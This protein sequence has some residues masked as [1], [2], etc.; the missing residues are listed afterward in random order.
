MRK[1]RELFLGKGIDWLGPRPG[2]NSVQEVLSMAI[3]RWDP[4]RD[5]LNL[6][7]EIGR[8][9]GRPLGEWE[10]FG[11]GIWTPAIDMFESDS[12][13]VVKAELPGLTAK[14]IDV[15]VD[16]DM[17]TIRG[18]R[19]FSREAKEENYYRLERR[20]GAFERTLPLPSTIQKNKAKASFKEG[21]LEIRMPKAKGVEAKRVKVAVEAGESKKVEVKKKR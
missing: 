16:D 5:L 7:D 10:P 9:F 2:P 3:I 21:V 17:L 11:R 12:E 18:E 19:K 6:P 4:W 15:T 1:N 8:F 14:D 20:Y 13:V